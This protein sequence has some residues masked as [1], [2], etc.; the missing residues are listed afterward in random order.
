MVCGQLWALEVV[1]LG[2]LLTFHLL[3]Q[4]DCEHHPEE[5]GCSVPTPGQARGS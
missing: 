1:V 5:P 2:L 4:P 3:L